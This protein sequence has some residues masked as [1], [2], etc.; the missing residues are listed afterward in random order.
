MPRTFGY[1]EKHDTARMIEWLSDRAGV[2][3]ERIGL[4]GVRHVVEPFRIA[5]QNFR[6]SRS[7]PLIWV[8]MPD[9]VAGGVSD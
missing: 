1:F 9:D 2:A 4:W 8:S 5:G 7:Q 3:S 6:F